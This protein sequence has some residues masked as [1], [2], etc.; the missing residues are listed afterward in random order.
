MKMNISTRL[1]VVGGVALAAVFIVAAM[2][3]LA[4]RNVERLGAE[5][6]TEGIAE[7]TLATDLAVSFHQQQAHVRAVSTQ[8][9][10]EK[11][12]M[13]RRRVVALSAE[14][15]GRINKHVEAGGD[16]SNAGGFE[17]LLEALDLYEVEVLK[18][19]D[20]AAGHE[21]EKSIEQLEGPAEAARR[22]VGGRLQ[23]ITDFSILHARAIV[24][25]MR[26]SG[27]EL[28][29]MELLV[30][31][32]LLLVLGS[33]GYVVVSRG[34]SRPI[35][36]MTL[37]M[38]RLAE[39][40]K[41]VDIPA[42]GN[43]DE[44]GDMARAVVVFRENMVEAERVAADGQAE[45]REKERRLEQVA[46]ER[47]RF[48]AA[49]GHDLR[50]PL[51]AIS[52]YLPALESRMASD[53]DRALVAAIESSCSAMHA[54]VD[55][56]LDISRLDAGAVE[57]HLVPVPIVDI[58]EQLE[59]E[60]RPQAAAK[61]LEMSVE[62]VAGWVVTDQALLLRMLR[63][64]LSNAIRYT[65]E[66]RV[67]LS[68][69]RSGPRLIVEVRDSGIGIPEDQL[70]HIFEEF[71][72]VD[73]PER[74]RSQGLGLGLAIIDRLASLLGHRI[75][76]D[77]SPGRGTVFSLEL[78]LT[79]APVQRH[80]AVGDVAA[81]PALAD[82]SGRLAVL[83]EDDDAVREATE[84]MLTDWGCEVIA[85]DSGAM[86]A[87]DIADSGRVPDFIVADLRLRGQETGVDAIASIRH[88]AGGPVPAVIVTGDTDPSRLREVAASDCVLLHKPLQAR[89]FREEL[90][91]LLE[92][93]PKAVNKKSLRY[94]NM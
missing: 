7:M 57:Q 51:H 78:P 76:V 39:G 26:A 90:V 62:P 8:F 23:T 32:G 11:L 19:F 14:M 33:A 75:D 49:A 83:V 73:N 34:I 31:A 17:S 91:A 22:A 46:A 55:S 44:I 82:M 64:L 9:D 77:S 63:N 13:E 15:K 60:F 36:D 37:V 89:R 24:G 53:K 20:L 45:R 25:K 74:D 68:A 52:L 10:P 21:W 3:I 58:F 93:H 12:A 6:Y 59:V 84:Y 47:T 70:E 87:A 38:G 28:L 42:M 65:R 35:R 71:Y 61:S 92:K 30:V 41:S 86:A 72:Q 48:F 4:V 85:A 88:A 18:A 40:D 56:L 29:L 16:H 67:A 80:D 94:V 79:D 50:Q 66:G 43:S 1:A 81:E 5:L 27:D 69:R 2:S 54:L